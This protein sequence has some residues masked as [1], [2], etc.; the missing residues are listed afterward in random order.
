VTPGIALS[1]IQSIPDPTDCM[2]VRPKE[3]HDSRKTILSEYLFSKH[4]FVFIPRSQRQSASFRDDIF[5][6]ADTDIRDD[7][8]IES[9]SH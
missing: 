8:A 1:C 3:I 4:N 5:S 2:C 7:I 6:G 9:N